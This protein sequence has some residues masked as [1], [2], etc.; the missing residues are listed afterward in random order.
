MAGSG[1]FALGAV[2]GGLVGAAIGVLTAPK[3]GKETRDELK[4]KAGSAKQGALNK[5]DEIGEEVS[6][7]ARDARTRAEQVAD[8]AKVKGGEVKEVVDDYRNRSENAVKG[9]VDG[10]KKGFNKKA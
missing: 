9:A 1:K 5:A 4:V 10:A 8:E 7:R 6:K 2:I 3:S